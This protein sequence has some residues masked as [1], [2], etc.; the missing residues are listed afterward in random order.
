MKM[1]H[2]LSAALLSTAIATS[3]MADTNKMTGFYVGVNGGY[4]VGHSESKSTPVG[5]LPKVTHGM[6]GFVGGLH[7]GYQK[8]FGCMVAGLELAGNL[9]AN[10]GK[11]EALSPT[12]TFKRKN[13]FGAAARLG[14]KANSWL[15]YGK[16]GYESAKFAVSQRTSSGK[17]HNAFVPGLGMETMLTNN[18]MFGG[19]WTYAMYSNKKHAVLTSP[20]KVSLKPSFS[21]FKLRLGYKF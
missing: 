10:K 2:I 6:K 11:D 4:G 7:A 1:N 15:V 12:L 3:A 17:R 18:V 20:E 16:L 14:F 9:S 13:A 5:N 8:D 21:D 19:E